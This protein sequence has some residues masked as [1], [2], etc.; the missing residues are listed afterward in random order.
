MYGENLSGDVYQVSESVYAYDSAG[1]PT[2]DY[3]A[4]LDTAQPY[5]ETVGSGHF[6]L[7]SQL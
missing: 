1:I 4:V 2:G 6:L 7:K 3:K 5:Y